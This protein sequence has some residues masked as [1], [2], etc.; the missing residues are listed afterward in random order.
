MLF[1]TVILAS[2]LGVAIFGL[3]SAISVVVVGRWKE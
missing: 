1:G 3:F 2:A